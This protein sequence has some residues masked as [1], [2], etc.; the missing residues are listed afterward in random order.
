VTDTPETR[1][2]LLVRV[3]NAS[4]QEAWTEFVDL[5]R[6]VIYRLA[7]RRGM[8]DADAQ[9]LAQ[10][11]LV[12]V[13]KALPRW[14]RQP[15]TR[16][17]HWLVRI[18]KNAI[19]NALMRTPPEQ[20]AGGTTIQNVLQQY[21]DSEEATEEAIQTEYR[22]ELFRRA[23]RHV[24]EDVDLD[25]WRAFWM[26]MVEGQEIDEVSRKLEKSIGSVYAAR[27][28]VMRRLRDKVRQWDEP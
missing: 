16:F 17:R 13:S 9:D 2:S 1:D 25:T 14:N 7:R 10:Q 27:S 6:P 23:A 3:K 5:Y 26:T 24:R 22:R 12:S 8:Q 18:A 21:P 4:D 19:L 15:G 11:V 28:R 20:A